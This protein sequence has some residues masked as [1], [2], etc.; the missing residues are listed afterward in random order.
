M[1]QR[2]IELQLQRGRLLDRIAQQRD[3]LGQ[4]TEPVARMLHLG[5]RVAAIASQCKRTVIENPLTTA[6]VLG[7]ALVIRPRAMLRWAQRGFLAWRSW[8]SLR[9]AL[10]RYNTLP[11]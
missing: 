1:Q 8:N 3:A 2:L 11:R 7:V 9:S 6:A 10:A 5:D 4:Q